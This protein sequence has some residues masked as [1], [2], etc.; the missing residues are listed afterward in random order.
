MGKI[1]LDPVED[2]LEA[3]NLNALIERWLSSQDIAVATVTA[4]AYRHKVR[5][6]VTWWESTGPHHD[7]QLTQSRLKD[8]VAHLGSVKSKRFGEPLSYNTRHAIV[9][10]LRMMFRWAMLNAY[11][12]KNYG[13]WV[14]WPSGS[15]PKRKAATVEQLARLMLAAGESR[16]PL[17]DTALLAFFIGT[18]CRRGEVAGLAVE[19]LT[20]L[21]DCT[22]T[23]RVIGK[24]TKANQSGERVVGFDASTGKWLISY[25]DALIINSGPLWIDD[26]GE[27]L[28]AQSIYEVVKRAIRRAGLES[29]L[30][31]CH[32]LR[33][34]FATILG[35]MHPDSPAW[36]DMIRRQLGHSTYAMTTV[37]TLLDADDLRGNISSPLNT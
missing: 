20:I 14:P 4:E 15:A 19:D 28:K 6:F 17:R 16:Q 24:R 10:A 12:E 22:G 35:R 31:G 25:M 9:R 18:G 21:A 26:N 34:A 3:Q 29:H 33:R 30:Q 13:E 27:R 7:W 2:Y 36:H 23:A 5:H 32:D 37:Y 1:N 8:F 11:T